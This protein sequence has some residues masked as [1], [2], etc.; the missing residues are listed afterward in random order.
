MTTIQV[1]N[2][3]ASNPNFETVVI[4]DSDDRTPMQAIDCLSCEVFEND[5]MI[6]STLEKNV[7][8]VY[9]K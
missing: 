1:I 7:L 4:K 6:N 8:L 2:Y 3:I 5:W 9:D